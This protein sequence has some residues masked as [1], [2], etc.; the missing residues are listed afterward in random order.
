MLSMLHSQIIFINCLQSLTIFFHISDLEKLT[1]KS[2][3]ILEMDVNH[4]QI[5][6]MRFKNYGS[7]IL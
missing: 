6:R 5:S 4:I 1:V 7:N 3:I 2:I